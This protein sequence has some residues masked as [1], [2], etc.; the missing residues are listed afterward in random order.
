MCSKFGRLNT[1]SRLWKPTAGTAEQGENWEGW[2]LKIFFS[3]KRPT[4]TVSSDSMQ[5]KTRLEFSYRK[6]Y[7]EVI[8]KISNFR[9]SLFKKCNSSCNRI[10]HWFERRKT[11]YK[12]FINSKQLLT[13]FGLKKL[14]I[15]F[16][17]SDKTD[18]KLCRSWKYKTLCRTKRRGG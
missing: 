16:I 11:K 13:L 1:A 8:W 18:E 6:Y 14:V 5:E 2:Q 15:F 10:F 4:Y 7:T 17:S 3:N 12:T 9:R